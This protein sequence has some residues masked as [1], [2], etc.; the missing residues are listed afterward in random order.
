MQAIYL[1]HITFI[2]D[3]VSCCM[4]WEIVEK[5][6]NFEKNFFYLKMSLA[7]VLTAVTTWMFAK[8]YFEKDISLP[9]EPVNHWKIAFFIL[10][11]VMVV[12]LMIYMIW[13]CRKRWRIS[14]CVIK[15]IPWYKDP[16]PVYNRRVAP[17]SSPKDHRHGR[18]RHGESRDNGN[19]RRSSTHSSSSSTP[20]AKAASDRGRAATQHRGMMNNDND[21]AH[22]VGLNQST[23]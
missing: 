16:Q 10:L 5:K 13:Y 9:I 7:V 12:I 4:P 21:A 20:H 8:N 19:H 6:T 2:S 17:P 3:S 22:R 11:T 23:I 14:R 15:T 1:K 18:A